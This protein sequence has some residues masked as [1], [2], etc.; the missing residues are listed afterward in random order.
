VRKYA[1][2]RVDLLDLSSNRKQSRYFDEAVLDAPELP[3]HLFASPDAELERRAAELQQKNV[4]PWMLTFD[5]LLADTGFVAE[6]REMLTELEKAYAHPVDVEFSA[7]FVDRDTYSI[8]VLQCRPFQVR[9]K[10][11]EISI[12]QG[13]RA[14]NV[15]FRTQGPIIGNGF[16]AAVDRL[17]YVVAGAYS[18]MKQGDRYALARLIG[19]ITHL[20]GPRKAETIMLVGPGR[21]GTTT[22]SL[23]VPVAFAEIDTVTILCECALMHEGLIPDVSLGTHFFNDIVELNM[24]YLA[25]YPERPGH[26]LNRAFLE[27]A[28]NA[29]PNLLP[30]AAGWENAVRV[31]DSSVLPK[32]SR[33]YLSANT[34]QQEGVC[35]LEPAAAPGT[36]L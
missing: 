3:L 35:F 20:G 27:S 28:H 33:L 14:E 10:A 26:I 4:F 11:A 32:G 23:G 36:E 13:L 16:S 30:D 6:M 7:N 2:R 22:P 29:L 34:Y 12:P 25:I 24:L 21:W 5:E 9:G 8:N 18:E 15:L 31:I 17:V 19:R 1:Q